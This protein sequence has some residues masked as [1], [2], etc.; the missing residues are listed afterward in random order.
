LVVVKH[1]AN[2]ARLARGTENRLED[3]PMLHTLARVIHVVSVGLWFGAVVMFNFIVAPTQFFEAFPAAV[4]SAPSDRTAYVPISQGLNEER[5]KELA[6][7]LAGSAVGPVFPKFFQ[8]QAACGALA[9]ITAIGWWRSPGKV[10]RVRA[11]VLLLAAAT[12]AVGWPIS[13]QVSAL[14]IERYNPDAAIAEAAKASF[15]ELHFISLGLSMLTAA[16][17]GLAVVL[18]AKMPERSTHQAA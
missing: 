11:V 4:E 16:L 1:R 17:A 9:L 15:S 13:N 7:A 10:H 8:L 2:L 5:K 18:A 12:V 3:K 14:R 6:T